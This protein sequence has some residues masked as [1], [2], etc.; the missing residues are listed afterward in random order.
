L[1]ERVTPVERLLRSERVVVAS[2]LVVLVALAWVYLVRTASY[3]SSMGAMRVEMADMV[4]PQVN[5][6]R[7]AEAGFAFAMWTVMMVAMMIP[8][9][10]PT[11]LMFLAVSRRRVAAGRPGVPFHVFL[12]GYLAAWTG[13]SALATGAQW[14]LHG[15]SLLS[16]RMALAS[17]AWAG[18]VLVSAGLFQWTP[19]KR[20]CLAHCRSPLSFLMSRWREGAAGAFAMGLRHGIYCVGCCWVLMAVLFAVGVMN[21][22]WVAALALLVL[23]EKVAPFGETVGRIGGIGLVAGGVFLWI[24]P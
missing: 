9:A 13:F 20:A 17:P 15:L 14:T 23:V 8:S 1:V 16:P 24:R 10:A 4:M 21:L 18:A 7:P 5:S 3:M 22:L 11:L 12:L 2:S 6:W 19:L